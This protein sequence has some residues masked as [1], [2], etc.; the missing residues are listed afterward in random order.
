[1][2]TANAAAACGLRQTG[3]DWPVLVPHLLR[4]DEL[5]VEYIGGY[6]AGGVLD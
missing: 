4:L 5:G 1:M 3:G 6:L 2:V